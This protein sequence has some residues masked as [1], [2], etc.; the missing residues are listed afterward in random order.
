MTCDFTNEIR[1]KIGN[2]IQ[3]ILDGTCQRVDINPGAKVYL[4]KNVIR[5]DLKV[6]DD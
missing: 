1:E 2:A 5:I 6:K 3:T 4:V